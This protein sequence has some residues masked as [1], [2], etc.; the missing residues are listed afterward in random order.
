MLPGAQTMTK[1]E[2]IDV[3]RFGGGLRDVVEKVNQLI[4]LA[5]GDKPAA[6]PKAKPKAKAKAK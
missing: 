4:A 5:N 2:P 3:D 6:K 1:I